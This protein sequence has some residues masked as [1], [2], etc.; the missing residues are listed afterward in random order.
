MREAEEA[1]LQDPEQ[2]G[3]E[4]EPGREERRGEVRILAPP[5]R[6]S[7][8]PC[9]P[10]GRRTEGGD[11]TVQSQAGWERTRQARQVAATSLTE[12]SWISSL[13]RANESGWTELQDPN[14]ASPYAQPARIGSIVGI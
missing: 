10:H 13:R 2:L 7:I 6:L 8:L 5:S 3:V 14:P 12:S 11:S 4:K 1:A 9:H